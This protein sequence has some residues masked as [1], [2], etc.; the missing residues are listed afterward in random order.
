VSAKAEDADTA[1]IVHFQIG[2]L[3]YIE[4]VLT[5]L[6]DQIMSEFAFAKLR[7]EEQL[8]YTV[9]TVAHTV[10]SV[11][12][13][14]IYVESNGKDAVYL[15][16]RIENFLQTTW[17]D[18]V[19]SLTEEDFYDYKSTT[20]V[21]LSGISASLSDQ[22]EIYLDQ[23]V[24][25]N[26]DWHSALLMEAK[27]ENITLDNFKTFS[28]RYITDANTRRRLSIHYLGSNPVETQ[29]NFQQ[30]PVEDL[31]SFQGQSSSYPDPPVNDAN[32]D[33]DIYV[34]PTQFNTL[35]VYVVAYWWLGLIVGPLLVII[36]VLIHMYTFFTPS[37]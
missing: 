8:G 31:S 21:K 15:D 10:H 13:F 28:Q 32:V 25:E 12:G 1:V 14:S 36:F 17:L 7:T 35:Y 6:T 37:L 5:Q 16:N 3:N 24:N 27:L 19:N 23:I 11:V 2:S 18:V 9:G 4:A 30:T 29:I 26:M 22:G 33:P 34:H 20:A